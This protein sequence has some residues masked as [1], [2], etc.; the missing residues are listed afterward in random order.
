M[1]TVMHAIAGDIRADN[2]AI[3]V[4]A[5][6]H[7]ALGGGSPGVGIIERLEVAGANGV[8]K[9]VVNAVAVDVVTN[10]LPVVVNA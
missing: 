3:V 2:F 10:D 4:D 9:A 5:L 7:R 8:E 6:S 1:E